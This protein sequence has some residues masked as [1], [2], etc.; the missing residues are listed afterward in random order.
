MKPTKIAKISPASNKQWASRKLEFHSSEN[1][2]VSS[3]QKFQNFLES[4]VKFEWKTRVKLSD[5]LTRQIPGSVCKTDK[6]WET[7]EIDQIYLW[8]SKTSVAVDCLM[9]AETVL[10]QIVPIGWIYV[11]LVC[12]FYKKKK[13]F[14]ANCFLFIQL[15]NQ[16]A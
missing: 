10:I 14:S 2:K 13:K 7:I 3:E 12:K 6:I 4:W 8:F 9:K 5:A 1:Q 16:S 15:F 11:R